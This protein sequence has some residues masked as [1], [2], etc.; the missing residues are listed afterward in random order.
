MKVESHLSPAAMAVARR[1]RF[2][3]TIKEFQQYISRAKIVVVE[4]AGLVGLVVLLF[5]G[6]M[7]ELRW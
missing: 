5:R 1:R 6:L 4:I 7:N 2:W 3:P